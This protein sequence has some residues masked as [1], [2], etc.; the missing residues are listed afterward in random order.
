MQGERIREME[1]DLERLIG[2]H[3]V[4]IQ[5]E[6]G[7]ITEV[8][9]LSDPNRR[10]K[11]IVRDVVTTL[12]AKHGIRVPYQKI[13][14][15]GAAL[16]P[17]PPPRP[18]PPVTPSRIEISAVHL[19]REGELLQATVELRDGC[20]TVRTTAER[21]ATRANQL[22]VVAAATIE[23]VRRLSPGL[24]PMHLDEACLVTVGGIR[25]VVA[26]VVHLSPHG[27]RS[28]IGSCRGE[29]GLMEA[30]AGAA[31]D[32]VARG[33]AAEETPREEVEYVVEEDRAE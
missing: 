1:A 15:A 30:A 10:P 28:L 23:G 14:V 18:S 17:D 31:L 29:D 24:G 12:F 25:V 8:H 11:W 19:G 3:S 22:R 2:V 16:A 27:E 5:A 33:V 26:H 4:R 32:A 9:V 7:E 6:D 13:S 21:L 20:Q